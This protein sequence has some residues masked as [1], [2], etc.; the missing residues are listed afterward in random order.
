MYS[1]CLPFDGASQWSA[2]HRYHIGRSGMV[3]SYPRGCRGYWPWVLLGDVHLLA[4][5]QGSLP[6]GQRCALQGRES[7]R[8]YGGSL[9]RDFGG[10]RGYYEGS[11]RTGCRLVGPRARA[12]KEVQ[13]HFRGVF[14]DED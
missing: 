2:I 4:V 3:V 13:Q 10:G 5:G 12:Q 1:G 9:E 14:A 6:Q 7:R 11:G 8:D